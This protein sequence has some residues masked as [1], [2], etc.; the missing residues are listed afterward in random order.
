MST[1]KI[2][3]IL[4]VYNGGEYLPL[5]V[6]SVLAQAGAD[7]ELLIVDDCSTDGSREYLSNLKQERVI[8]FS[9]ETNQGLFR[10]LNFLVS[11]A[12]APLIKLWA[13]DD[14]MYPGCL[15]S[16][17]EFHATHSQVGFSYS[18]VH[19]IN[20]RGAYSKLEKEDDTPEI[21]SCDLHAAIAFDV[22]SIAGNIANTCITT[23]ALNK[24]G[25]FNESMR[26][27]ADFDMWVR[28]ARYFP[29]GFIRKPLIKLRDHAGQL[30]R[31]EKYY[32]NHVREDMQVYNYLE[33]YVSRDM[34]NLGRKK[35][36]QKKFVFYYTLM[37]KTFL[38]GNFQNAAQYFSSLSRKDN[39]ML[40]TVEFIKAK[41]F[42]KIKK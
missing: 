42:K 35:L 11:K 24:V 12:G 30:S 23:Q 25:L 15:R 19:Y 3:V 10:N 39:I 33:S 1:P 38:K 13:Q 41:V 21:V 40:L 7:F 9:N 8:V 4:P 31:N 14:I 27:S 37:V 28:I 22:G 2:S 36:R 29:V 16:F 6:E 26:I 32:I 5:S 17:V 18:K 34:R 20:E